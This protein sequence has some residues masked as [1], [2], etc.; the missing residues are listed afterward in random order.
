MKNDE[1]QEKTESGNRKKI[2]PNEGDTKDR[3]RKE[4]RQKDE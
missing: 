3:L 2:R 4:K 1:N